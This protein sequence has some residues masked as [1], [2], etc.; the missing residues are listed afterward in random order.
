VDTCLLSLLSNQAMPIIKKVDCLL[1]RDM[2]YHGRRVT[3]FFLAC[4]VLASS[5]YPS[6]LYQRH[7]FSYPK[8]SYHPTFLPAHVLFA[9]KCQMIFSQNDFFWPLQN[10][11]FISSDLLSHT[12]HCTS[13][14]TRVTSCRHVR[15]R[16]TEREV[17]RVFLRPVRLSEDHTVGL[18]WDAS[19]DKEHTA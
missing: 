15:G 1:I 8:F 5:L 11:E 9:M 7:N 6:G 17:I 18:P 14:H 12:I 13:L 4:S 16:M 2:N 3:A 19:T 10:S